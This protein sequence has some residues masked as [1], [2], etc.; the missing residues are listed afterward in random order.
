MNHDTLRRQCPASHIARRDDRHAPPDG[1][2]VSAILRQDLGVPNKRKGI[3]HAIPGPDGDAFAWRVCCNYSH[4]VN[5]LRLA[6]FAL[7][8]RGAFDRFVGGLRS[9]SLVWFAGVTAVP[10]AAA[11]AGIALIVALIAVPVAFGRALNGLL[12]GFRPSVFVRLASAV[13][14]CRF[15]RI[16]P[17]QARVGKS[18]GRRKE[19][20]EHQHRRQDDLKLPHYWPPVGS[21][22]FVKTWAD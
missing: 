9:R 1:K 17:I 7:P 22:P 15:P 6:A 2:L 11:V 16:S 8:G 12:S 3:S 10:I 18:V 4:P 21:Q 14:V 13:T 20:P 5:L 19:Q